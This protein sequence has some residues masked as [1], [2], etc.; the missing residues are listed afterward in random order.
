MRQDG[1]G[2]HIP[3]PETLRPGDDF[4]RGWFVDRWTPAHLPKF[5]P[6]GQRLFTSNRDGLV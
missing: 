3:V 2:C 4:A 1:G 5:L 6:D